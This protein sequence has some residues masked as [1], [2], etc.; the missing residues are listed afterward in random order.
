MAELRE[1]VT[2]HPTVQ[3]LLAPWFSPEY[4]QTPEL[5]EYVVAHAVAAPTLSR[6][7]Y[8]YEEQKADWEAAVA[9]F[10]E[11]GWSVDA[12]ISPFVAF[13]ANEAVAQTFAQQ[14]VYGLVLVVTGLQGVS[15]EGMVNQSGVEGVEVTHEQ[16]WLVGAGQQVKFERV[17]EKGDLRVLYGQAIVEEESELA[18]EDAVELKEAPE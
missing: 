10:L 15:V 17:E 9:Q 13:S 1:E 5:A 6:G 3:D 2:P 14:A 16:E 7:I 12:A 4:A 11:S 18:V 8:W